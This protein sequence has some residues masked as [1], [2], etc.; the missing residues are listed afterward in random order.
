MTGLQ[1]Y[2]G[3][4]IIPTIC[5]RTTRRMVGTAISTSP[6]VLVH[7]R[8]P[9]VTIILLSFPR[10]SWPNFTQLKQWT[11]IGTKTWNWNW[12]GCILKAKY[13]L[14]YMYACDLIRNCV[15]KLA[16]MRHWQWMYKQ[17]LDQMSWQNHGQALTVPWHRNFNIPVFWNRNS[18]S[19]TLSTLVWYFNV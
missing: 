10:I 8:R 13:G 18:S 11:Q 17:L 3:D 2:S 16:L 9:A 7:Q 6:A 14:F 19:S 5:L 15:R 1:A 4:R 12:T